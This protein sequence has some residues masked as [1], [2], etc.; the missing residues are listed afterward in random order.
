MRQEIL[1]PEAN[2]DVIF[3]LDFV[4]IVCWIWEVFWIERE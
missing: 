4:E 1:T 2:F 3:L